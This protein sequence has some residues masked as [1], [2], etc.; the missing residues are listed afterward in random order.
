MAS[1]AR[2]D[3]YLIKSVVH[4]SALLK[5]FQTAG[6][7]LR[8]RDLTARTQLSKGIVF[9]MLHT[10]ERCGL[11]EKVGDNRYR[12]L[13]RATRQRKFKIGYAVPGHR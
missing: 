8:L 3:P 11:M 10:L 4:A 7:T 5:A 13:M 2:E 6:E 12:T 9:R 1:V